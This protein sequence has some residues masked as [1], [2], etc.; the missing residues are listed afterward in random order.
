MIEAFG[1]Q[2]ENLYI[3]LACRGPFGIGAPPARRMRDMDASVAM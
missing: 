3:A 2:E 1:G